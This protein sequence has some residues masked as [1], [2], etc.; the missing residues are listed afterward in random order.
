[1]DFVRSTVGENQI[2]IK[3]GCD[4]AEV[5]ILINR[6]LLNRIRYSTF[7]RDFTITRLPDLSIVI[8][9]ISHFNT[10]C[11]KAKIEETVSG[12]E[13]EV[14]GE[15]DK[16]A[17]SLEYLN[18]R[19]EENLKHEAFE[20][21]FGSYKVAPWVPKEEVRRYEEA[22]AI[23]RNFCRRLLQGNL[24]LEERRQEFRDFFN[25]STAEKLSLKF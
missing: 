21:L 6:D 23:A 3:E 24:K 2:L 9:E 18:E 7:P 1:M 16:F 25:L 8:E 20:A 13:L 19:N 11:H 15:V 4:E 12:L 5:A 22:H 10:Y 17:L 14:Q